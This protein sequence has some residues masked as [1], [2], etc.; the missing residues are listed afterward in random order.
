MPC[1]CCDDNW[2]AGVHSSVT[3]RERT[4]LAPRAGHFFGCARVPRIDPMNNAAPSV[5]PHYRAFIPTTSC[6]V[7]VLRFCTLV[8]AVRAA[9]TSPLASERQVLTFRTQEPG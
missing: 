1:R 7:P 6:S 9:W 8:L 5:Q 2:G 4:R 3:I